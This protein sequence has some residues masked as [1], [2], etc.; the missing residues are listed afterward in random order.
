MKQKLEQSNASINLNESYS[1][2]NN[3]SFSIISTNTIKR[4]Y[5]VK[6]HFHLDGETHTK[7]Q[8]FMSHCS[9]SKNIL[10]FLDSFNN[11]WELIK[12]IDLEANTLLG[13]SENIVSVTSIIK[14]N[15]VISNR[16]KLNW[17]T[18]K[19]KFCIIDHEES[20]RSKLLNIEIK[21]NEISFNR[22]SELDI[23]KITDMNF[24]HIIRDI[25]E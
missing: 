25:N 21:D 23:S 4:K 17:I 11:I 24:S 13:N 8:E 1:H 12:R 9:P 20:P 6:D 3:S 10:F 16:S 15:I 14:E 7:F 5:N 2:L 18:P 22:E 19:S